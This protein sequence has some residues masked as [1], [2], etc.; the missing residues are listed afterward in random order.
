MMLSNQDLRQISQVLI[1]WVGAEKQAAG[2]TETSGWGPLFWQ[3]AARLSQEY[4]VSCQLRQRLQEREVYARLPET[5]Q[6]DLDGVIQQQSLNQSVLDQWLSVLQRLQQQGIEVLPCGDSALVFLFDDK[7]IDKC[8]ADVDLSVLV[9]PHSEARLRQ[10]L[11]DA[12]WVSDSDDSAVCRQYVRHH[13]GKPEALLVYTAVVAEEMGIHCDMTADYLIAAKPQKR[14]DQTVL[15]SGKQAIMHHLL[16]RVGADLMAQKLEVGLL[17]DISKLAKRLSISEWKAIVL[18]AKRKQDVRFLYASLVMSARINA[19]GVPSWV[20]RDL[21]PKA[22][23]LLKLWL[24]K[25]DVFTVS[26]ANF[27]PR[28]FL[29]YLVWFPLSGEFFRIAWAILKQPDHPVFSGYPGCKRMLS[30]LSGK[31]KRGGH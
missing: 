3:E 28:S 20:V 17:L 31:M 15:L 11:E 21:A 4:G 13:E 10:Y 1:S 2:L 7:A 9:R 22:P 18:S 30:S 14:Q 25:V 8:L 29:D 26:S 19:S 16:M 6:K 23:L 5:F 27:S 12:H 24:D